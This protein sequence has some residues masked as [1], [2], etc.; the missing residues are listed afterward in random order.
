MTMKKNKKKIKRFI[1]I[2]LICSL[3]LTSGCLIM[4]EC[5]NDLKCWGGFY[6]TSKVDYIGNRDL[7]EI[8]AYQSSDLIAIEARL[9]QWSGG[10]KDLGNRLII[11]S[12][13]NFRNE[14]LTNK[15]ETKKYFKG[16][17]LTLYNIS[18]YTD[19][20]KDNIDLKT[21]KN[22]YLLPNNL[23]EKI[24]NSE[25]DKI[26][27]SMQL[28]PFS[29]EGDEDFFN[30]RH[31]IFNNR[32]TNYFVTAYFQNPYYK[33]FMSNSLKV[34]LYPPAF[35]VDAVT[36]PLIIVSIPIRYT[37]FFLNYGPGP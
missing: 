25:L 28:I 32:E 35:I 9:V 12:K 16:K 7:E 11:T 19:W 26:K 2:Y 31:I 34:L 22:W 23:N 13:D 36:L 17:F 29:P 27:N 1:S 10:R 24:P 33:P 14:I 37:I 8:N 5:R 20:D 21:G 15:S 6:F 30:N 3:L 4:K 18:V